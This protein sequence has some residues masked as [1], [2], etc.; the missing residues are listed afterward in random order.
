MK[1]ILNAMRPARLRMQL[2]LEL[3]PRLIQITIRRGGIVR[4]ALSPRG[5]YFATGGSD[6]AVEVRRTSDLRLKTGPFV[7]PGS[8][9]RVA[10]SHDGNRLAAACGSDVY[11]WNVSTGKLEG[12]RFDLRG[13]RETT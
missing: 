10:I 8:V 9:Y 7:H 4:T 1:T 5:D 3:A 6:G 11:I 2:G 12:E 13:S